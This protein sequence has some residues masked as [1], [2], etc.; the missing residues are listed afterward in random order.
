[1]T[2]EQ[3]YE[4]AKREWL[5]VLMQLWTAIGKPV[6]PERLKVYRDQLSIVPLGLLE[7]AI[8]R[9]MQENTWSNVPPVGTIWQAIRKI[10]GNP[11]DLTGELSVW[12]PM[13]RSRVMQVELI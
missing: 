10:L 3:I 1:M 11:Y 12:R 9:V 6:E 8:T 13:P 4:S 5:S 7:L 2:D